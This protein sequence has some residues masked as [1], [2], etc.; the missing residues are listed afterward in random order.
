MS[1]MKAIFYRK[2]FYDR[3]KWENDLYKRD[4]YVNGTD[5]FALVIIL[6]PFIHLSNKYKNYLHDLLEELGIQE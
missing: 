5:L 6:T 4:F 1:L 2:F 3:R